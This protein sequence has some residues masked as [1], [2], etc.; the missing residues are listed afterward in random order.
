MEH[1]VAA[2]LSGPVR[3]AFWPMVV[4]GTQQNLRRMQRAGR[5]HHHS[6]PQFDW[7]SS[8]QRAN[9][10]NPGSIG[11]QRQYFALIKNLATG[12]EQSRIQACDASICL[13]SARTNPTY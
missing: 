9:A 3:Q 12:I 7:L 10:P 4:A 1:Q 5:Q 6:R 11:V 13:A 2:N 8:M